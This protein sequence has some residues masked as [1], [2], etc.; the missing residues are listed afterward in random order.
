MDFFK[1]VVSKTGNVGTYI[2][3]LQKCLNVLE[4]ELNI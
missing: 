1:N 4:V 3:P 2:L